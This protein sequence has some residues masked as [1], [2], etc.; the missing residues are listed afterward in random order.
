MKSLHARFGEKKCSDT[1]GYTFH[2]CLDKAESCFH[3]DHD[4]VHMTMLQACSFEGLVI[5]I[6]LHADDRQRCGAIR[7]S[8]RFF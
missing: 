7:D 1:A 6:Y 4:S 2:F 3:E 8:G 5:G